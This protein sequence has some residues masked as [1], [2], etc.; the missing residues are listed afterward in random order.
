MRF[1]L[2][3]FGLHLLGSTVVLTLVLGSFYLG[4]YRWPGWYLTDASTVL[5]VLVGVDLALGPMLTLVVAQ[6]TKPR[7]ELRRDIAVIVVVQISALLYGTVSLWMGRPLYYAFSESVLQLVQS[8][9]ISAG[10]LALGRSQNA[11][12]TPHWYSLPRWIWAPL[13]QD[14]D[15]RARIVSAALSGGDDVISMPRYYQSW[16]QGL[17]TLQRQMKQVDHVAYFSPG[18]K[19]GLKAAM[20]T[21]G[22]PVDQFNAIPLT[23]RG[24]PLLVV[25]DPV[26]LRL[27][28]YCKLTRSHAGSAVCQRVAP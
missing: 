4:W 23:G 13:P 9:D 26:S 2:R 10:E 8:Y 5:A 17:S 25:F 19:Q 20:G 6:S 24:A 22:L 27:R 1:R 12:L 15:E 14:P 7:A 28:A 18:Q 11:E 3:A 21:A 16:E